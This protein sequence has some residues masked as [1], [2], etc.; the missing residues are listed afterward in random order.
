MEPSK[1]KERSP[2]CTRSWVEQKNVHDVHDPESVALQGRVEK[3]YR[4]ADLYLA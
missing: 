2:P 4:Y 3:G 1:S